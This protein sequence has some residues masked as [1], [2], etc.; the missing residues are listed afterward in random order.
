MK[1][2][3]FTLIEMIIVMALTTLILGILY[4]IFHAGNKVFSDADVRS[5][6]QM[7]ARNIQEE[8]TSIGMQGIG[9]TDIKINE[10]SYDNDHKPYVDKKY[11]DMQTNIIRAIE[12]KAYNKDSEYSRDENGNENISNLQTYNITFNDGILAVGSK[13]LS[14]NVESFNVVPQN[15][16]DSFANASSIEF[17]IVLRSKR[18]FSKVPDYP[19]TVKV[20]FRNKGN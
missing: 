17:N 20:T 12:I 6:L 10:S 5:T 3:G 14:K 4:S 8:L 19:I 15:T 16:D 7:D 9:V 13:V 18:G 11:S 2:S 1:K